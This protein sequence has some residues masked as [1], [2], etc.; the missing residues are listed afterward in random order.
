[1]CSNITFGWEAYSKHNS[2]EMLLVFKAKKKSRGEGKQEK[3]NGL[4]VIGKRMQRYERRGE[5]TLWEKSKWKEG[6]ERKEESWQ[7]SNPNEGDWEE[8]K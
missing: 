3:R 5:G 1:M 8:E 4:D 6:T 7:R 2:S